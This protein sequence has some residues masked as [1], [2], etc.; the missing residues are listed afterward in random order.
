MR[1]GRDDASDPKA[2]VG[3]MRNSAVACAINEKALGTD[4]PDVATA[5]TNLAELYRVQGRYPEAEPLYRQRKAQARSREFPEHGPCSMMVGN[6]MNKCVNRKDKGSAMR[7]EI[8]QLEE[9]RRVSL[10]R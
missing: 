1:R 4:H 10:W 2:S 9:P 8:R 3:P 7:P 6:V 5:L